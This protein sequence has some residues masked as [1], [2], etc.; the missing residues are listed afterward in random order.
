MR[1]KL[2]PSILSA[3]FK[4]LGE[5]I[6]KTEEGGAEYLHFDV[7]DGMFVPNISFGAPVLK[8][9]QGHTKQVLDVHLMVTEPIRY[10][11]VFAKAGADIITVHTE[12]CQD[13]QATITEIR[14]QG[15]K[16]GVTIKPATPVSVV[17]PILDQV[18]MVLIMSVEPGFGGQK[19]IP[20]SLDKVRELKK[21]IDER[22]L[23]VDIEIDGGVTVDN[24][25]E[26]AEA[27][28]NVFVAGSSVFG[29]D[30]VAKTRQFMEI[31]MYYE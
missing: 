1:M 27:G 9:I 5:E 19:F 4:E 18:D 12:A 2:A 6:K 30:I 17:T 11:E 29:G 14:R 25:A 8:S 31:L 22:N 10:I 15:V 20:E 28:V 3:D 23:S 26:I 24:A 13:L 21:M 16:V 7:M